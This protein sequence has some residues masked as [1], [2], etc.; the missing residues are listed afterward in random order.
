MIAARR[1]VV[2]YWIWPDAARGVLAVAAIAAA[3][4][5]VC[6]G[7]SL[8]RSAA[9]VVP[10]PE[11]CV[12]VN[13]VPAAV[14]DTL[15]HFGQT[16]VRQVVAAREMRP[17]TS[18]EDA[19]RRVRGLGPATLA[20]I[21]PYVRFPE[22]EPA[23]DAHPP[24]SLVDQPAVKPRASRRKTRVRSRK[25]GAI[26][27]QPQLVLRS[28]EPGCFDRVKR[29]KLRRARLTATNRSSRFHR[30]LAAVYGARSRAFQ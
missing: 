8:P 25:P 7:G 23:V 4:G 12:D 16:L 19:G 29:G 22:S 13:V 5:L 17:I 28:V 9:D 27:P 1:C 6:G 11:L 26:S 20:K 24:D 2:V 3:V 15:P 21:A 10:A 18:L 14:L 30:S